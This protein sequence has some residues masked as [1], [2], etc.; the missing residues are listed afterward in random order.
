MTDWKRFEDCVPVEM[1]GVVC[2]AIST[3]TLTVFEVQPYTDEP[4]VG[5][6]WCGVHDEIAN[7]VQEDW[8]SFAE[9]NFFTHWSYIDPPETK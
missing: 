3:R 4:D 5:W 9:E 7:A 1:R 2:C 6:E 8:V